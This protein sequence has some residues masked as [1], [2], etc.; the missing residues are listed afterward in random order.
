MNLIYRYDP[1]R[2]DPEQAG[3]IIPVIGQLHAV[4]SSAKAAPP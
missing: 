3:D 4:V 2:I 1:L